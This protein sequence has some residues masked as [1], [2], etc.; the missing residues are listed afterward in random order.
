VRLRVTCSRWRSG[1]ALPRSA[2]TRARGRRRDR[3]LSVV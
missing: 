3:S 2:A 1:Y